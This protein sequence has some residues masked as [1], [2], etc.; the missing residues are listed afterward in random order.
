MTQLFIIQIIINKIQSKTKEVLKMARLKLKKNSRAK[1][2]TK[3]P[4]V[5]KK[6]YKKLDKGI[7]QE[8][9]AKIKEITDS[10][11]GEESKKLDALRR[12][13]KDSFTNLSEIESNLL[14]SYILKQYE[15]RLK[16]LEES[17]D[18]GQLANIDLQNAMQKQQ[19]T[20][21]TLS[22]TSKV[23]HDNAM[24]IIRKIG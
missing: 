14:E 15:E 20:L 23:L 11:R 17:G 24:A 3:N 13:V 12:G 8:A 19:Q 21:Q 4:R 9:K 18:D 6:T 5:I 1:G 16:E 10:M 22:N 2:V 7:S